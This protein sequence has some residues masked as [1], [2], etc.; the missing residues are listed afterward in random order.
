MLGTVFLIFTVYH[1]T[2]KTP[3]HKKIEGCVNDTITIKGKIVE[4]YPL[5]GS[6]LKILYKDFSNKYI[7]AIYDECTG[8][9]IQEL[10]IQQEK[11][12]QSKPENSYEKDRH[13]DDEVIS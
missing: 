4:I 2:F 8:S 7:L 13:L 6:V 1:K 5:N 11:E 3:E 12:A 10:T 9:K